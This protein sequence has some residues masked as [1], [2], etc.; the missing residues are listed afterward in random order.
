M[1]DK[2]FTTVEFARFF[3][4]NLIFCDV[5]FEDT[6][7]FFR[8]IATTLEQ[9]GYVRPTFY[10]AI[11]ERE[12]NYPTGLAT[13]TG[14]VAIPHVDPEHIRKTFIAV[15]RPQLP[16]AFAPMGGSPGDEPIQAKLIFVLGVMRGG[17]QVQVL[18]KLM[19]M[20]ADRATMDRLFAAENKEQILL[21]INDS[22]K[23]PKGA[24]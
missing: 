6:A 3:T 21:I 16:I 2:E 18:Q 14:G 20:L 11:T 13:A 1:S 24:M 22:F 12:A 7:A 5:T 17:L 23:N 10:R 9:S 15:V 4:S 19:G 8:W